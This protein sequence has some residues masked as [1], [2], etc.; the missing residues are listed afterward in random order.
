MVLTKRYVFA[1]VIL[2]LCGK[3]FSQGNPVLMS[4]EIQSIERK[5]ADSKLPL[6]ERKRALTNMARLFELSGNMEGAAE[7]WN[8]AAKAVPGSLDHG[9]LLRGTLCL[10]AIGEFERAN[11]ELRPVLSS[12]DH[13][14][15]TNA[16]FISVQIESLMTG[17]VDALMNLAANPDFTEYKPGI[18]YSIWKIAGD[19]SA[20]TRLM[21]EFP[22]SPEARIARDSAM[23]AAPV[24]AAPTA[25]WLLAP[26]GAG[27]SVVRTGNAQNSIPQ[28]RQNSG[29]AQSSTVI[30]PSPG[31]AGGPVML[32]TGFFSREE[33]A[34][35]LAERLRRAGFSP[36]VA[37]KTVNGSEHWAVGVVPGPDPSKTLLLLK[38]QG[39]ESFPVY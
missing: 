12:P 7:A 2:L 24:I 9:A 34:V 15:Q 36:M 17:K 28:S 10:S 5:L 37:K 4:A 11:T 6:A 29:A 27:F 1:A 25:M 33:N 16:R 14:M 26:A 20:K 22:Q 35:A 38:D 19:G 18:Y 21:E 32:Q 30:A 31:P 3:V 8:E 13:R 23:E 39:F